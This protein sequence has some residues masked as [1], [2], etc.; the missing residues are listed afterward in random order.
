ML[1]EKNGSLTADLVLHGSAKRGFGVHDV[2]DMLFGTNNPVP[3][4][5]RSKAVGFGGFL[6]VELDKFFGPPLQTTEKV[7]AQQGQKASGAV[8]GTAFAAYSALRETQLSWKDAKRWE[9]IMP[10]AMRNVSSAV[11]GAVSGG[12]RT[13]TGGQIVE[14]DVRDPQGAAEVIGMGMGYS[15]YR[16]NYE[17]E[18]AMAKHDAAKMV[19]IRRTQIMGQFGNAVLGKDPEERAKMTQAVR[20]FNAV[21]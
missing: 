10:R 4:F 2:G 12:E 8:F 15:P 7:L 17:W 18:K 20:D 3:M 19:D 1:G 16:K 11:R 14:Y 21:A 5:D 6:P 13:K 9:A